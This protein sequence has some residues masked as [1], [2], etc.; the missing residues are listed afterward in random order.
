MAMTSVGIFPNTTDGLSAAAEGEY[1]W[2]APATP[3]DPVTLYR[4][5]SGVA[6]LIATNPTQEQLQAAIDQSEALAAMFPHDEYVLFIFNDNASVVAVGGYPFARYVT[7]AS[8]M[9]HAFVEIT[10]GDAG[11][12]VDVLFRKNGVAAATIETIVQGTPL[13][14]SSI[15]VS[16]EVGDELRAEIVEVR[17][18]VYGVWAQLDGA[19]V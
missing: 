18:N 6:V 8:V 15:S 17:G 2:V 3:A 1:F 19:V 5:V 11:S 7:T 14:D 13:D 12:E 16:V 10:N 4:D 9:T